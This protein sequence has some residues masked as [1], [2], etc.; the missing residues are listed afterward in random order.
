MAATK[1]TTLF[2]LAAVKGWLRV[3]DAGQD[4]QIAQ[5]ADAVSARMEAA[6]K[7]I[8]VRRTLS[9]VC[10]GDGSRRL[11]LKKYP[12]VSV[13]TLT[14]KSTPDQL[15]PTAYV[16]GTDFDADLT[17]GRLQMRNLPFV[18]GFQNVAVTYVAGWD[19]QDGP[20]LPADIYQA[21]LDYVKAVYQEYSTNAIAASS[22][23]LGPTTF[24]LKP[25]LPYGIKRVLDQWR[26][27]SL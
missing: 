22:V 27:G 7:R 24:L 11:F 12:V 23:S 4:S 18:R 19:A 3:T 13:T 9:E 1:A 15:T 25:D 5:I 6:T 14:V 16:A 2:G 20:A 17:T 26:G 21:G 10:D 8:F